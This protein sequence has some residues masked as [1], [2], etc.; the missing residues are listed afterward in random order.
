MLRRFQFATN[1]RVS[2]F[3]TLKVINVIF[4][5]PLFDASCRETQ[6]IGYFMVTAIMK[7]SCRPATLTSCG[8]HWTDNF[9]DWHKPIRLVFIL[10]GDH[11]EKLV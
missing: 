11:F 2:T 3:V 8:S 6:V 10:P 5:Y 4:G 9:D 7:N 1:G